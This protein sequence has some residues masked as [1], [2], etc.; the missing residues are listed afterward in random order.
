MGQK[1]SKVNRDFVHHLVVG[2]GV[3]FL[4]LDGS[5]RLAAAEPGCGGV[6]P[7]GAG[8]AE[9][10]GQAPERTGRCSVSPF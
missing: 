6:G 1:V 9:L 10:A 4:P 8:S 5:I 3:G 7:G 2:V